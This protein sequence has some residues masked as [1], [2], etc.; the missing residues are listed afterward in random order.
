M[1]NLPKDIQEHIAS[2]LD[3]KSRARL[4]AVS[5]DMKRAVNAT[6]PPT[7]SY[8]KKSGRFQKRFGEKGMQSCL[9]KMDNAVRESGITLADMSVVEMYSTGRMMWRVLKKSYKKNRL[10]EDFRHVLRQKTEPEFVNEI[11]KTFPDLELDRSVR[12]DLRQDWKDE[13]K[14]FKDYRRRV[15]RLIKAWAKTD[16][17]YRETLP[18]VRRRSKPYTTNEEKMHKDRLMD[19]I[20]V[21]T[22]V[23]S[24]SDDP[25]KPIPRQ[26][27]TLMTLQEKIDRLVQRCQSR[28]S[29]SL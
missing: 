4:A 12:E 16:A 18:L 19:A 23:I 11:L 20:I 6:G 28:Y 15:I 14:H 7:G 24:H 9:S 29:K 21:Q 8:Q 5:K 1:K 26:D 17:R 13:K 25:T 3:P 22:L 10:L 27:G 2:T